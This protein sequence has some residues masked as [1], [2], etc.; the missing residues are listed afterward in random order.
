MGVSTAWMPL[1][2]GEGEAHAARPP[3]AAASASEGITGYG[4]SSAV[5]RK[6]V[7]CNSIFHHLNEAYGLIFCRAGRARRQRRTVRNPASMRAGCGFAAFG[8][9]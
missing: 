8:R 2:G 3:S 4:R 5:R 1:H 6:V 7:A 9:V